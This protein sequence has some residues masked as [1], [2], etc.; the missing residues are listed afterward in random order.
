M[1]FTYRLSLGSLLLELSLRS[2][3]RVFLLPRR[4]GISATGLL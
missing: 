2:S 3:Q 1:D 4:V